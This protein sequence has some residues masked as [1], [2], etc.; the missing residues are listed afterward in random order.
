M[1]ERESWDELVEEK[2]KQRAEAGKTAGRPGAPA[3]AGAPGS[4]ARP[5]LDPLDPSGCMLD[6]YN[7]AHILKTKIWQHL[8]DKKNTKTCD[9]AS[10]EDGDT[11]LMIRSRENSGSDEMI[12]PSPTHS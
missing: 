8:N 1:G 3:W 10:W 5:R 9:P 2:R 12:I 7:G 11:C 4:V 6:V